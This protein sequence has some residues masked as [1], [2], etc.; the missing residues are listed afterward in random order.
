M[1]KS[2]LT[3]E[4]MIK[5]V[6][7][8]ETVFCLQAWACNMHGRA[9]SQAYSKDDGGPDSCRKGTA[10]MQTEEGSPRDWNQ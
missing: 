5:D 4:V 2:D 1:A 3:C 9:S 10:L 8:A 6:A 7:V